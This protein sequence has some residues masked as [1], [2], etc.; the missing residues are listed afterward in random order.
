MAAAT[1]VDIVGHALD[2]GDSL[3]QGTRSK[4]FIDPAVKYREASVDL[5]QE[6]KELCDGTVRP[7]AS[8]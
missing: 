8:D 4:G 2:P 1:A 6:V 7:W 3:S 5:P